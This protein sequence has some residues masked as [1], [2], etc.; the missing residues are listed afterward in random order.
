[1]HA[2]CMQLACSLHTIMQEVAGCSSM[3]AAC[4][5]VA[6]S[7]SV[8]FLGVDALHAACMQPALRFKCSHLHW[9]IRAHS[10]RRPRDAGR[11]TPC[12]PGLTP[13]TPTSTP[14]ACSCIRI[15][16]DNN[17]THRPE[18]PYLLASVWNGPMC[19]VIY[20]SRLTIISVYYWWTAGRWAGAQCTQFHSSDAQT[21]RHTHT[22]ED[23]VSHEPV[24][25][26]TPARV[27]SLVVGSLVWVWAVHTLFIDL[28]FRWELERSNVS[29]DTTFHH[30]GEQK[31]KP[32]VLSV[33]LEAGE[34]WPPKF[35]A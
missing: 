35:G 24:V 13:C 11:S 20:Y 34:H 8:Y 21:H 14:C 4:M 15:F 31:L 7:F 28:T 17:I 30:L 5:Q 19:W 12:I 22:V 32:I 25:R 29:I 1:M 23:N 33:H 27:V 3:H 6:S 9:N 2:G 18:R 26:T 10:R 16:A